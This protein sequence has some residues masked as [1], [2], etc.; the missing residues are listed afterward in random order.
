MFPS[1]S[2]EGED[3]CLGDLVW[4]VFF[5]EFDDGVGEGADDF[6]CL[7]VFGLRGHG[8]VIPYWRFSSV[9][10]DSMFIP[11]WLTGFMPSLWSFAHDRIRFWFMSM[12]TWEYF[13]GVCGGYLGRFGGWLSI[14]RMCWVE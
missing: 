11:L 14:W 1:G 2:G 6:E 7:F 4:W 13:S 10:D 8:V 9:V 12:A 3:E 5:G